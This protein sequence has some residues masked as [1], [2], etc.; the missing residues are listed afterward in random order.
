MDTKIGLEE[1]HFMNTDKGYIMCSST[2][3]D[4]TD[5]KENEHTT[6]LLWEKERSQIAKMWWEDVK[7]YIIKILDINK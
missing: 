7:K 4:A 6:K 3:Y 5:F 1:T 2:V